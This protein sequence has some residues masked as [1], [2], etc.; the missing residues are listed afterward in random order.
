MKLLESPRYQD[1]LVLSI[2]ESIRA[3][4]G[5]APIVRDLKAGRVE[6]VK[7]AYDLIKGKK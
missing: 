3:L 7:R 4:P 2:I 1:R 5:S 6:A